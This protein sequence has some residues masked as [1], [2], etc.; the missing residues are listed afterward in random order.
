VTLVLKDGDYGDADG[1][2]NGII[3]DPSG[4]VYSSSGSTTTTGGSSSGCFIATAAYGSYMEPHV[5]V[6]RDFRDRFLLSNTVG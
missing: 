5:M 2:A 6:L 4:P 3:V 1:T